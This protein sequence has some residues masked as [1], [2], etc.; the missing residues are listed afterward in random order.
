MHQ[1]LSFPASSPA[2]AAALDLARSTC[3]RLASALGG[4]L[5]AAYLHGSAVLGGYRPDRSDLDFLARPDAQLANAD[6]AAV[7]A[8]LDRGAYPARGLEL[9]LRTTAEAALPGTHAPRFQLHVATSG[10][11]G[12]IRVVDG[13]QRE[14]D[15]D[16]IL[17]FAVCR[18]AGVTLLE[19]PPDETLRSICTSDLAQAMLDEIEWAAF[20]APPAY[21]VLTCARAWLF[22]VTDRIASKIEAGEW[23]A[24]RYP[25]PGPIESALIAQS[26]RRGRGGP[27]GGGGAR[28]IRRRVDP[29]VA[30]DQRAEPRAVNAHDCAN[31]SRQP[32]ARRC[33]HEPRHPGPGR[34]SVRR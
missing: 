11:D 24:E 19:P 8:S 32:R 29:P 1:D 22:A 25:E 3:A 23:A 26:R 30:R 31:R 20:A 15:R 13:R 5:V 18:V 28:P 33:V 7:V 9:R 16:L 12:P 10:I 17:H 2:D 34:A 21:L 27:A 4:N 6:V 14:G